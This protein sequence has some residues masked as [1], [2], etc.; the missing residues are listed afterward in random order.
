M[1]AA[2]ASGTS[3]I[4][5]NYA[6]GDNHNTI[7]QAVATETVYVTC[8]VYSGTD[9]NYVEYDN[10]SFT[11]V[12]PS[13]TGSNSL[14]PDG[15]IKDSTLD[16]YRY[17]NDGGT[18]SHDGAYYSLKWVPSAAGDYMNY[19]SST[20]T[21]DPEWV[22]RFAG[23]TVTIGAWV[24][25]G[26]GSHFKIGF[27]DGSDRLGSY[28]GAGGWEWMEYTHT[29]GDSITAFCTLFQSTQTS[30]DV[31]ISQPMLVIGNSIGEGNYTRPKNEIVWCET[32]ISSEHFKN[33]TDMADVGWT[34]LDLETDSLHRIPTG[35]K[36]GRYYLTVKDTTSTSSGADCYV[37]A[38]G[39]AN[40][41]NSEMGMD[42]EEVPD[43]CSVAQAGWMQFREGTSIIYTHYESG[44]DTMTAS[45]YWSAIQLQ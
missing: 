40:Y 7:Y 14:A 6:V 33:S 23:K 8:Q 41:A 43:N 15:W 31:Y 3:R 5:T 1:T 2:G 22:Q 18:Y 16:L 32:P 37:Y 24:H 35:A 17:E 45:I 38:Y 26:T 20:R 21:S 44:T 42:M 39:S 30:G 34:T 25:C 11:Q 12:V 36:A 9:G 10:V 29:C 13:C 19:P 28:H 27:Y 4:E